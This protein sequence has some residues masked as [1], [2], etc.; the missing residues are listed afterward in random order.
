M[1]CFGL[2]GENVPMDPREPGDPIIVTHILG[3]DLPPVGGDTWL[4]EEE[5]ACP[6][7]MHGQQCWGVQ[8]RGTGC[9]NPDCPRNNRNG[10]F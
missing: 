1:L 5:E 8:I 10:G 4:D 3:K 6:V 7:V 9:T 2:N